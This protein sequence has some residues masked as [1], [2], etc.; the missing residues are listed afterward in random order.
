M[1]NETYY[2]P[3]NFTDAGR[4]MGLFEIRNLIEAVLLTLP[5]LY[6]CLAF[7]PLSMTPKIIVTLTV[8]VPVG[9]FGLIGVSDDSLT[10]WLGSWWRWRKGRRLITYRGE[11]KKK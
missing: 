3:A 2:I 7:V 11:C 8:L 5:I 4:V 6:L 9:G 10:R 1:T